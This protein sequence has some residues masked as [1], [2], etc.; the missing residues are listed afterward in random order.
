MRAYLSA[1]ILSLPF[2][3]H[4]QS[5]NHQHHAHSGAAEIAP[6]N[7]QYHSPKFA[8]NMQRHGNDR[9]S[10]RQST[11]HGRQLQQNRHRKHG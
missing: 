8:P 4:S 7:Y 9:I 10:P 11:T 2:L 1:L 6:K 3:A 5:Y